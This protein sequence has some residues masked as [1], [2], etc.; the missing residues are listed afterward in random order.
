M[1]NSKKCKITLFFDNDK[2]NFLDKNLC[3]NVIPILIEDKTDIYTEKYN[4]YTTKIVYNNYLGSLT[5]GAFIYGQYVR[6]KTKFNID[7]YDP[8]SG[9]NKY[10]I[11]K[12][13]CPFMANLNALI[14][15][16]DRTLTVFEGL[17]SIFPHV[18]DLLKYF[19]LKSEVCIKD[20]AE[21]Y[22]GG[23][24]RIRLLRKVWKSAK[25]N[26]TPIYILSSNP[27]VGKYPTFFFELLNSVKLNVPLENIIFRGKRT[28][29]EYIRD[30]L[31]FIC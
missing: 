4:T 27:S 22:L 11:K 23:Y 1:N 24:D 14:F 7:S 28:K 8:I 15:D 9:I 10:H 26:K 30:K 18:K 29:Y 31:S 17:Y 6:N 13:M 25:D 19:S 5:Y 2:N 12:L 3:K 20:V 16:W 21:Y